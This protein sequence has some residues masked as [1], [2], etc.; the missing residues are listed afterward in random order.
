MQSSSHCQ[1]Q[2]VGRDDFIPVAMNAGSRNDP[3]ALAFHSLQ[4]CAASQQLT[5]QRRS[6]RL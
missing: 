5:P 3:R 4:W 1:E 2:A 6:P